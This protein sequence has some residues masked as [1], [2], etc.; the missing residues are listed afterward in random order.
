MNGRQKRGTLSFLQARANALHSICDIL[1]FG[2]IF[3]VFY[4]VIVDFITLWLNLI[5]A[6]FFYYNMIKFYHVLK[7]S[8]IIKRD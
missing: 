7:K 4:H 8:A 3:L 2:L 6:I 5:F 1:A